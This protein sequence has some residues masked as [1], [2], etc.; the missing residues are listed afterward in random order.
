MDGD[1]IRFPWGIPGAESTALSLY[2]IPEARDV[3]SMNIR[4]KP[5]T[6]ARIV[7]QM[8][9]GEQI[10]V[11]GMT[12]DSDWSHVYWVN[13]RGRLKQGYIYT[14][15]LDCID[16]PIYKPSWLA[17]IGT[18]LSFLVAIVFLAG[19]VGGV[20]VMAQE[21]YALGLAIIFVCFRISYAGWERVLFELFTINLPA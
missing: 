17:R 8:P 16:Y 1:K 6:N 13:A 12:S 21:E 19:I 11:C 9:K 20:L 4:T 14:K 10:G 18:F 15:S 5:T 2:S 7:A 3:N